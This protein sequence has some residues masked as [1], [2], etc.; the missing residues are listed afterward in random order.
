MACCLPS[1][2]N[3]Y[4]TDA[5]LAADI[6]SDLPYLLIWGTSDATAFPFLI[7]KSREYIPKYQDIALEGRGHWL[8][9]EAKDE[10]TENI[11]KWLDGLSF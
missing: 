10:I 9:V 2:I 6:R 4:C 7:T 1:S 5:G 3:I 8:L 11:M